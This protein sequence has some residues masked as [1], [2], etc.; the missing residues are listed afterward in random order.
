MENLL[1]I[2]ERISSALDSYIVIETLKTKE[3]LSEED[4]N[5]IQRNID[6]LK[7]VLQ[8]EEFLNSIT[9]TDLV[10]LNKHI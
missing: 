10:K 7:I 1:T 8:D 6:H 9:E 3:S 5:T 4:V 2:E